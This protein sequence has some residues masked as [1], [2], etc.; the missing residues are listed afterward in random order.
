MTLQLQFVEPRL[1]RLKMKTIQGG[2]T[3]FTRREAADYLGCS[4]SFLEKKATNEPD[5]IPFVK[6]GKCVKY[7]IKDL[8]AYIESRKH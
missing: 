7:S 6:I 2:G 8:D 1:M 5:L 4:I 3:M